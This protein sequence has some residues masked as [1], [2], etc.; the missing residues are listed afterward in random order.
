MSSYIIQCNRTS[1]T[2]SCKTPRRDINSGLFKISLGQMF[3]KTAYPIRK[4]KHPT[5]VYRLLVLTD[6]NYTMQN[7]LWRDKS[8]DKRKRQRL[9]Y[10]FENGT[11]DSRNSKCIP[12]SI[13]WYSAIFFRSPNPLT[14][15]PVISDSTG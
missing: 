12:G 15:W 2:Y 5:S 9:L 13:S 10:V 14:G 8:F 3:S 1:A 7:S 11:S 6:I 4:N